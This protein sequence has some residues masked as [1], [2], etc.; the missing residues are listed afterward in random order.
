MP[1][2][3]R[4]AKGAGLDYATVT[5]MTAGVDL[6]RALT[7]I[8]P[9]R[10]RTLRNV[11]LQE[12]G[13]WTPYPGFDTLSTTSLGGTYCQGAARIYLAGVTPF[14]LAA[15]SGAVYKPS[16]AGVWG[17]SVTTGLNVNNEVFFTHDRDLVG[18]CDSA[19]IPKKS[20]DG[21]TWTQFGISP[22]AAAPSLS[23]VAGGSLV[24]GNTYEVSYS[25]QD[26]GLTYEGNESAVATVTPSGAN[27]TIRVSHTASADPQVEKI[28][29]YARDV[30]AGELVRRR[31]TQ[32]TNA[33]TTTDLTTN[34]W[35]AG[36]EAPSDHTVTPAV[37]FGVVW[38][39]RWWLRDATT[40]N[41]LRFSQV[42]MPQAVPGLYYI[43]IP[44][45]R[46]D[47]I[48]ALVP[49]GDTLAVFGDTKVYLIIGQTSLDFEV[50]PSSGA[51]TGAFG[52]RAVCVVE[53]GIIHASAPGVYIFDGATDRLLSQDLDVA[54]RDMVGN[55][56]VVDLQRVAC[57]YHDPR[58]EVH[59]AVPRLY[60]TGTAGEWILDLTRTRLQDDPSWTSTTRAI[61]GYISWDG[62]ET[63]TGNRGRLFSWMTT[64]GKI[65]EEC[66][67]TSAD[68]A[69]MV[70]EYEGAALA[71]AE[72]RVCRYL[73]L[74]G[75]VQQAD[76]TF[77]L[78]VYAD[79]ALVSSHTADIGSALSV[80]GVAT[81]GSGLYGSGT[82]RYFTFELPLTAEGRSVQ[83]RARYT[84]QGFFK[85]FTYGIGFRPE[86]QFRGI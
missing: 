61:A 76:G 43:D 16:D 52:P 73:H 32:V 33:T 84:G 55:T 59:V 71:P 51:V 15:Y 50:R 36:V 44:F 8:Q 77:G 42:F 21:T 53:Q 31:V 41:R 56:V 47:E 48:R 69:D 27:L 24:S 35:T 60:P 20:T 83:V 58:K 75:E 39:N 2:K 4:Q 13:A 85:W 10:A 68:G 67:G 30:T 65:V 57:V 70:C 14:T 46:G 22:P 72:F 12:P 62:A 26:D 6:R 49:L 9:S 82:R 25:Y 29:I 45:E 19:N 79:D 18:V 54:W 28:N 66:V 86:P 3:T 37:S 1:T 81:Y 17:S 78:E 74:I 80:Y 5:D 38:R 23:A 64:A 34:N 63:V 11:S 40:K 7:L